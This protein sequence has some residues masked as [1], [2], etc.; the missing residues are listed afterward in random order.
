MGSSITAGYAATQL[1]L[2]SGHAC[3][4]QVPQGRGWSDLR[5]VAWINPKP[6]G[7]RHQADDPLFKRVYALR[8][9]RAPAKAAR[10]KGI[11][12]RGPGADAS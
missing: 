8:S 9:R 3:L 2:S 12:A 10:L 1:A 4:R 5:R 6:M 7:A 11:A